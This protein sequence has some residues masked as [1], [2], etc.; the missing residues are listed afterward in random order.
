MTSVIETFT[1]FRGRGHSTN[2]EKEGNVFLIQAEHL[3]EPFG[4]SNRTALFLN[5]SDTQRQQFNCCRYI[6][7]R[8]QATPSCCQGGKHSSSLL[9]HIL[10]AVQIYFHLM[11][12][13]DECSLG[14]E[15]V[16]LKINLP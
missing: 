16:S 11:K 15:C 13:S 2:E 14:A 4:S 12:V 10:T 3:L 1:T 8:L 6:W 5:A 7:T 9:S